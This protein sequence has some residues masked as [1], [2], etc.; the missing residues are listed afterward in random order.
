MKKILYLL[1]ILV[2]SGLLG[3]GTFGPE[4]NLQP[5]GAFGVV[6]SEDIQGSLHIVVDRNDLALN[7]REGAMVFQTSDDTFH[8]WDGS[9]WILVDAGGGGSVTSLYTAKVSLTA[10][11]L[12][13]LNTTPINLINAQGAGQTLR[14]LAAEGFYTYDNSNA[15]NSSILQIRYT[16]AANSVMVTTPTLVSSTQNINFKFDDVIGNV[17][18]NTPVEIFAS[19]DLGS[20]ATGTLDIVLLYQVVNDSDGSVLVSSVG[21]SDEND[22]VTA[23]VVAGNTM[24]LTVPNQSNVDIDVSSLVGG[25]GSVTDGVGTTA[26]G[27][28][29]DLG[30]GNNV[31]SDRS[32]TVTH[33]N[34]FS[35]RGTVPGSDPTLSTAGVV[36]NDDPHFSIQGQF[37]DGG[38]VDFLR[39]QGYGGSGTYG[40]VTI[41]ADVNGDRFYFPVGE[42]TTVG[43]IY[44]PNSPTLTPGIRYSE[45]ITGS[46]NLTP[47]T[48][49]PKSYIDGLAN[50]AVGSNNEVQASDGSGS[51]KETGLLVSD[52]LG[53]ILLQPEATIGTL[54]VQSGS[55]PGTE[56]NLNGGM[57]IK[58]N[59]AAP[60]DGQIVSWDNSNNSILWINGGN[61]PNLQAVLDQGSS[62]S[63]DGGTFNITGNA[64]DTRL[65]VADNLITASV[66]NGNPEDAQLRI[67]S[68]NA[69]LFVDNDGT[70][71]YEIEAT[72]TTARMGYQSTTGTFSDYFEATSSGL[73]LV[74][75]NTINI[76]G[77]DVSNWD[78][79][80]SDDVQTLQDVIDNNSSVVTTNTI[81]LGV[82]DL[83]SNSAVLTQDNNLFNVT[84]QAGNEAAIDVSGGVVAITADDAITLDNLQYPSDADVTAATAGDAI[85]LNV[86]KTGFEFYTPSG[87]SL[88][89][90]ADGTGNELLVG[91][92]SETGN[93]TL[94]ARSSLTNADIQIVPKGTGRI[95]TSGTVYP[96]ADGALG[97]SS[98]G[99]LSAY[100]DNLFIGDNLSTGT[101][102]TITATGTEANID[103]NIVPKGTGQFLV[104][105][106]PVGGGGGD[107]FKVGSPVNNQ[108]GIWTGDGTLEGSVSLTFDGTNLNSQTFTSTTG[109]D[110]TIG[111]SAIST[112]TGDLSISAGDDVN[113]QSLIVT[114]T[115]GGAN[116]NTIGLNTS[117][118]SD[119]NVLILTGGG[120]SSGFAAIDRGAQ[121]SLRG[122]ETVSAP[123]DIDVTTG[124][125]GDVRFNMGVGAGST[126]G[127]TFFNDG[128]VTIGSPTGAS[129]GAGTLNVTGLY[130]NGVAVGAQEEVLEYAITD[131]TST[132]TS[133]TSKLTV[134]IPYACTLNQVRMSVSTEPTGA[135]LIVDIN[136]NGTTILSTKLSIDDGER[137]STTAASAAVIS[138]SSLADDAEI[139][140]DIDQIGS[141]TSGAG[142]KV[143]LYVTRT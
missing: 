124:D 16:G 24:T 66:V 50:P 4:G 117:D 98:A 38:Q 137:T 109:N 105:G 90:A 41:G 30:G 77:S 113:L 39:V 100:I 95:G 88:S 76:A 56:L 92:D 19:A 74:S 23:G 51:I 115:T 1:F 80:A 47:E 140:F 79:N 67:A 111:N 15:Y 42:S 83:G 18:S 104:N 102:R 35:F 63:I 36:T 9:A 134:R 139:T 20:V 33:G 7:L 59:I 114:E 73:N 125:G 72:G 99:Y 78:Q 11:N 58:N 126:V 110:I 40:L 21:P 129:Q 43:P 130:V 142:V 101:T 12:A 75:S 106:L 70:D 46:S 87:G 84:V 32:V 3:Q 91:S 49:M 25:G 138:D 31:T 143:K 48:L 131:E 61:S 132:F 118:G 22:F 54:N 136:E 17:L 62:G 86:G 29:V 44:K 127:A 6:H 119:N 128:G 13:N 89:N 122:N 141:T 133:G 68:N 123:G 97:L 85:R 5:V 69:S 112:S 14:V 26:N 28:S 120:L 37:T 81:S 64:T 53:S 65:Q 57:V 52:A 60:T 93:V 96:I 94:T 27:T 34:K 103:V 116:F 107:V 82:S 8:R 45:D 108:V 121:I 71:A 2:F 135:D 55:D 10:A